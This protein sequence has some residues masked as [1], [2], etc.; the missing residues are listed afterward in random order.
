MYLDRE[1]NPGKIP[2]APSKRESSIFG[3]LLYI[4]MLTCIFGLMAVILFPVASSINPGHVV[5]TWIL[6]KKM[7]QHW[8]YLITILSIVY[9]SI[10]GYFGV[11][12]IMQAFLCTLFFAQLHCFAPFCTV[13]HCS[14]QS[15]LH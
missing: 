14:Y 1:K 4:M 9:I 7:H 5:F 2:G 8:P 3:G 13:L 6:P 10:S 15:S 12:L 11:I